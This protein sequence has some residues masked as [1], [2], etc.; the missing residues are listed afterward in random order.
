ML[1][2]TGYQAFA[3]VLT[4]VA[5]T[6]VD[7][8]RRNILMGLGFAGC[9]IAVTLEMILTAKYLNSGNKA[10]LA[11]AVFAFFFYIFCYN[12]C[13]DGPALFYHAEIWP[14][15]MRAKGLT[16]GMAFYGGINIVWLQAAPTAFKNI[17]WKYYIIFIIFA[18]LGSFCAFFIYPN[19]LHKPLEEVAAMFKDYDLVQ[20][21]QNNLDTLRVPL[22][23]IEEVIPGVR[24]ERN[25]GKDG[26]RLEEVETGDVQACKTD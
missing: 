4:I 25:E 15:N 18:A 12:L 24:H 6:Y 19:T 16:L 11:A 23:A 21:Y 5:M 22:E 20:V 7:R 8:V 2:Q 1:F 10:G 3:F 13:L 9:C 17:G 14:T 26:I